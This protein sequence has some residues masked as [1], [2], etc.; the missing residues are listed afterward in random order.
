MQQKEGFFSRAIRW[1]R[2]TFTIVKE[3]QTPTEALDLLMQSQMAAIAQSR[4]DL[5]LVQASENRLNGILNSYRARSENYKMSAELALSLNQEEKA[6]TYMRRM[7]ESEKLIAEGEKQF[8]QVV[9]QRS[10]LAEL[11]EQ[12]RSG[13]ERL[14][15]RRESTAALE[16]TA[17]ASITGQEAMTPIGT[18]GKEKEVG[19]EQARLGLLDLQ[20]RALALSQ[21]RDAGNLDPVGAGEFDNV[22]IPDAEVKQ[23]LEALKP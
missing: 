22:Q 10:D 5:V 7:M 11:I 16:T 23:R 3:K 2:E 20:S 12:M 13:Y 8:A 17:K 14:R 21:L 15:M 1:F 6:Q 18:T 19:L 4:H 9:A